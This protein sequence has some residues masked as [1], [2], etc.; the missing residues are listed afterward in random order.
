MMLLSIFAA[1][2]PSAGAAP[3]SAGQ[4]GPTLPDAPQ[5]QS[6]VEA[7]KPPIDPCALENAAASMAS[8]AAVRGLELS[9]GRPVNTPARVA[10]TTLCV[11]HLPIIN[12]YA[13]FLNGPQVKPFTPLQ[14]AHQA[15]AN[16]IDPFNLL[17]I[18]GVAAITVAANPHSAYG[19]GIPG[20]AR[21]VGVS[22]SQDV[23][24][25]FFGAFLI[26]VLAHEDPHY[27]RMPNASTG[28]RIMHCI[29]QIF[30]TEGDNGKGMLNYSVLVGFAIENQIANLY[31]PGERTNLPSS[32]ERY[33]VALATAPADNFI[34]EFLPDFARHI[35]V[36]VVLVQRI[37]DQV[38]T[39]ESGPPLAAPALEDR[40]A[41]PRSLQAARSKAIESGISL[42]GVKTQK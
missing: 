2:L 3:A 7:S 42:H 18:G 21:Y 17:T 41:M 15:A 11:P 37:I 29:D 20:Y 13:R 19:P 9:A 31:V 30:W 14:K 36:R 27:H 10:M 35:H 38:A 33:G 32:A 5:A 12:W 6:A 1:C 4:S 23:T 40:A 22:L 26:P 28:R 39:I 16:V 25:E 34:T 24:D 8:T